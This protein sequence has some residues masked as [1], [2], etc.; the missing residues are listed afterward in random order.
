MVLKRPM[1]K[2]REKGI[3]ELDSKDGIGNSQCTN[4]SGDGRFKGIA[5]GSTILTTSS[6]PKFPQQDGLSRK[7]LSK[8]G[9]G[10]FWEEA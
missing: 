2:D 7:R 6:Y 1:E 4:G 3:W 9:Y 10:I 5:I 8:A